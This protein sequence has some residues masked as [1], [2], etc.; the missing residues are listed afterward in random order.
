MHL[1]SLE[2]VLIISTVLELN[3]L[4]QT[5]KSVKRKSVKDISIFTFLSITVI[6]TLWLIYGLSI[7]NIPLIIGNTFK[8]FASLSV[9]VIYFMY[10]KPTQS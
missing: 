2:Y 3:P 9:V 4:F 1:T 10:R 6:G 7:G 8:L 5:I